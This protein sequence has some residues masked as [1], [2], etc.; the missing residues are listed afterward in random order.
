MPNKLPGEDRLED[1]STTLN[2]PAVAPTSQ[3]S[4]EILTRQNAVALAV[5][6]IVAAET[7]MISHQR[8][9]LE[10]RLILIDQA[11]HRLNV[12]E[13]VARDNL[14][15]TSRHATVPPPNT[16][17]FGNEF[18]TD[19]SAQPFSDVEDMPWTQ[20]RLAKTG[21][22][23]GRNYDENTGEKLVGPQR[24]SSEDKVFWDWRNLSD[25][26]VPS[27]KPLSWSSNRRNPI[28]HDPRFKGLNELL[29]G[30]LHS[31]TLQGGPK[32]KSPIEQVLEEARHVKSQGKSKSEKLSDR[33]VLCLHLASDV[34]GEL[35]QSVFLTPDEITKVL[36]YANSDI[37]S[38]ENAQHTI[39]QFFLQR[40]LQEV[41]K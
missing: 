1:G 41:G 14:K 32:E 2:E 31:A 30:T 27:R 23:S 34:K 12:K 36:R 16:T 26:V 7:A 10:R 20:E 6:A 38:H 3:P 35:L 29:T 40:K 22:T 17:V 9:R 25:G 4:R 33:E 18:D 5:F 21:I 8:A 11:I 37:Y 13:G 39:R 28:K 15:K 19:Q 24:I